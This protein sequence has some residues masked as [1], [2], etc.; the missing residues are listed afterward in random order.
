MK[1]KILF[2][3]PFFLFGMFVGLRADPVIPITTSRN[4]SPLLRTRVAISP[5]L[6]FYSVNPHHAINPRQ[7]M[8]GMISAKGELR[9]NMKHTAFFLFGI[10]YMA[11]G[12][13]F[14]SYYFRQDSLQL[15]NGNFNYTYSLYVHEIDIPLQVKFSFRR[16]NNALVSPYIM[17]GYHFRTILFG[18]LDVTQN[19]ETVVKKTEALTFRNPLFTPHNNAFVSFTVGFQKNNPNQTRNCIFFEVMYRYGFSQYLLSDSFTPS[20]L[21]LN[22]S[23][24]ALSLGLKF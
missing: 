18:S 7:K 3:I 16:E 10:E 5:L 14:N 12:L 20:S 1:I 17:F 11:H 13:N 15:Y 23:H 8:S 24:I 2:S 19:G 4:K 21:Y 9:L 22:G 6:S